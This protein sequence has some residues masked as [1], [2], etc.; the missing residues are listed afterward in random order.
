MG[1]VRDRDGS[2]H[3]LITSVNQ[4]RS[5]GTLAASAAFDPHG[6]PVDW[7]T[8]DA[9]GKRFTMHI[10]RGEHST[11]VDIRAT[12]FDKDGN[13]R[14][15]EANNGLVRVEETTDPIGENVKFTHLSPA[16]KSTRAE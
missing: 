10:Q 9:T 4:F 13:E 1:A 16:R 8:V 2:V 6:N 12:F 5:D 3:E 7:W 15:W 11:G 14:I